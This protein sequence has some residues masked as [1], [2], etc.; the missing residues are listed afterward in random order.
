MTCPIFYWKYRA[1]QQIK[2]LIPTSFGCAQTSGLSSWWGEP[3]VARTWPIFYISSQGLWQSRSVG[4]RT[5]ES[6]VNPLSHCASQVAIEK[7]KTKGHD[8]KRLDSCN[9]WN[10]SVLQ[11]F[12]LPLFLHFLPLFSP[13]SSGCQTKARHGT[14]QA[15]GG[16]VREEQRGLRQQ[17]RGKGQ[18]PPFAAWQ[19]CRQVRQ[20]TEVVKV[21]L[22]G[23]GVCWC[24]PCWCCPCWCFP[25]WNASPNRSDECVLALWEAQ[26]RNQSIRSLN[27]FRFGHL[28]H[29]KAALE[30]KMLT[31]SQVSEK[32]F[33]L[34]EECAV[35]PYV[36]PTWMIRCP[37]QQKIS[38]STVAVQLAVC[39]SEK[40]F[41]LIFT[42]E[43]ANDVRCSC[44][45]LI[46]KH[47]WGVSTSRVLHH[48]WTNEPLP[49]HKGNS[50][51]PAN[52]FKR[53]DFPEP[54]GPMMAKSSPGATSPALPS[55][56]FTCLGE[57]AQHVHIQQIIVCWS[58]LCWFI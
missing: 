6:V 52:D 19:K 28:S 31:N 25:T 48:D 43:P 22:D 44:T 40:V 10:R 16:L 50:A 33:I 51:I 18:A 58:I 55:K 24:C 21:V 35:L 57:I 7:L 49:W 9:L 14:I 38:P 54:E 42:S 47:F 12:I 30:E 37:N 34:E 46:S 3:Q 26:F 29:A 23:I 56:I 39:T 8:F 45:I 32:L 20:V 13:S 15:A 17:L 5:L 53:V 1:F 2:V 36:L 27:T 11:H 41:P 4:P